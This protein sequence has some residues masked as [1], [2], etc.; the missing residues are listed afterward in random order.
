MSEEPS[1]IDIIKELGKNN[2]FFKS[3]MDFNEELKNLDSIID[4]YILVNKNFIK[5]NFEEAFHSFK[6]KL[7]MEYLAGTLFV[8]NENDVENI[9]RLFKLGGDTSTEIYKNQYLAIRKRISASIDSLHNMENKEW[10]YEI[11]VLVIIFRLLRFFILNG[12]ILYLRNKKFEQTNTLIFN[13]YKSNVFI[14][15]N[16][17]EFKYY[18]EYKN[19]ENQIELLKKEVEYLNDFVINYYGEDFRNVFRVSKIYFE[20]N[21]NTELFIKGEVGFRASFKI[22]QKLIGPLYLNKESYG[23]REMI[24]NAVDAC[25]K[26]KEEEYKKIIKIEYKE[27]NVP[28]III[29]DNGIGMNEEIII[30]KFLTVGESTKES[31]ESIGK[32]GIGILSAFLIADQFKFKTSYIDEDY[33]YESDEINLEKVQRNHSYININKRR[34]IENF[35]GTE[36]VLE[37]KDSIVE[38]SKVDKQAFIDSIKDDIEELLGIKKGYNHLWFG[39]VEFKKEVEKMIEDYNVNYIEFSNIFFKDKKFF[40]KNV[41]E[42]MK[43]IEDFTLK[44]SEKIEEKLIKIEENKE[45]IEI[46]LRK[47]K[48]KTEKIRENIEKLIYLDAYMV[49]KHLN[50]YDWYFINDDMEIN[51][52]SNDYECKTV[53]CR[54]II[55][56]DKNSHED[57]QLD[58]FRC[59]TN[60][61]I[62]KDDEMFD[63][64]EKIKSKIG[65]QYAWSVDSKLNGK[66]I[67]NN[68]L[69]PS[70]YEYTCNL[71]HVF[72][73]KPVIFIKEHNE[74]KLEI[75][76]AREKCKLVSNDVNYE[77]DILEE[78]ILDQLK[79]HSN[80]NLHDIENIFFK[81]SEI[82][83]IYL[84][85][86]YAIENIISDKSK[87]KY[88]IVLLKNTEKDNVDEFMDQ[89]NDECV[90]EII[91]SKLNIETTFNNLSINDLYL[92]ARYGFNIYFGKN[93]YD[94]IIEFS[95][96]HLKAI[97][98]SAQNFPVYVDV[99]TDNQ[100]KLNTNSLRDY[101][102]DTDYTNIIHD[103]LK[104]NEQ[105]IFCLKY[106][107]I[108]DCD[109]EKIKFYDNIQA[110][111]EFNICK[112][113]YSEIFEAISL[114]HNSRRNIWN[115]FQK[116]VYST[117]IENR[118]L[119]EILIKGI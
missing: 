116:G 84:K 21:K 27:T 78:I 50:A 20:E 19:V 109:C 101:K 81:S 71:I 41:E 33:I 107:D 83:K 12:K 1:E 112:D 56:Y 98:L 25:N 45:N 82:K 39:F 52:L 111:I 59:S 49:F 92:A 46:F 42:L 37:L 8:G 91:S 17:S 35:K 4:G 70:D 74:E 97:V 110:M 115:G 9:V 26:I 73:E 119:Q 80:I 94:E 96:T 86:R 43:K 106:Y 36:I 93:Y 113:N 88:R 7:I 60:L 72:K 64:T 53:K 69:I 61:G 47:I 16:I 54:K 117:N 55:K 2:E 51:F 14:C 57:N 75:N 22:I 13:D 66:V 18:E 31:E 32:F 67:C 68:M 76:L 100:L 108:K 30:N 99:Y 15:K 44:L 102:K 38:K 58:L 11:E 40:E 105:S 77:Q 3:D 95:T 90:Y 62:M 85:N 6:N 104:P 79:N 23:I 63:L 103:K 29:H 48:E 10:D 89:F 28:K 65:V 5:P 87:M 118:N 114:V 24:Q 34:N